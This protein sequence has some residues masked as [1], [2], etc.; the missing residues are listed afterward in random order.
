MTSTA[1]DSYFLVVR[2]RELRPGDV[3]LEP[4]ACGY[5]TAPPVAADPRGEQVFVTL[6]GG[7]P[8]PDLAAAKVRVYRPGSIDLLPPCP[9]AAAGLGQLHDGSC[10]RLHEL[11]EQAAELWPD[12]GRD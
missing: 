1:L 4:L 8:Y 9:C 3:V 5:V 11:V 6:D 7:Q 2:N 12:L 10:T